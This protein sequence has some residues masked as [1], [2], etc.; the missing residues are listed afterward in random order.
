MNFEKPNVTFTI[1]I[2]NKSIASADLCVMADE[3]L[4]EDLKSKGDWYYFN[5]IF[6]PTKHRNKGFGTKLMTQIADWADTCKINI[7]NDVSPYDEERL[8][9]LIRFYSK[10]GFS[11]LRMNTM[12]R[13]HKGDE[14]DRLYD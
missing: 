2:D 7:Y 6:V 4:D 1:F 5:R 10:Y 12:I 11:N 14:Y 8:D 13:I 3:I 9:D